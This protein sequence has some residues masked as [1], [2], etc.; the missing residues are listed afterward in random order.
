MR[1]TFFK[2]EFTTSSQF[3]SFNFV[4]PAHDFYFASCK[5]I[6]VLNCGIAAFVKSGGRER[7]IGTCCA[8]CC[9]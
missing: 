6:I 2:I 5:F 9:C 3:F 8:Y 7:K 1:I 4:K